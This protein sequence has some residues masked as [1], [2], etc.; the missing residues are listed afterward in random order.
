MGFIPR[1]HPLTL[2]VLLLDMKKLGK[3]DPTSYRQD[4][5]SKISYG[6]DRYLPCSKHAPCINL[7]NI[8]NVRK[9]T[10]SDAVSA[11]IVSHRL[12]STTDVTLSEIRELVGDEVADLVEELQFLEDYDL[13]LSDLAPKLDRLSKNAMLLV[14][15]IIYYKMKRIANHSHPEFTVDI[16][17][18]FVTRSATIYTHVQS[19][20][21]NMGRTIAPIISHIITD[22]GEMVVPIHWGY[23]SL[24]K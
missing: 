12:T 15:L 19:M 8:K 20:Q 3:Y 10:P 2:E 11:A 17:E 14:L 4:K 21:N 9:Y 7:D 6:K 24:R 5:R 13:S 1:N 16:C 22:I 23:Q 18:D